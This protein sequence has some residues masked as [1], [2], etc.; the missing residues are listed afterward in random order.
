MSIPYSGG[1]LC[2]AVRYTCDAEPMM[3][4][5]CQCVQ[6]RKLSG[7]AHASMFAIPKPMLDISGVL[8]FYEF[9]A[10][11]GNNVK[12]GFCPECG[13]PVYN[14]N[15]GFPELGFLHASS[16]DDPELFKPEL[17]IYTSSAVAWDKVDDSL[18]AFPKMPPMGEK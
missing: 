7:S 6:C 15:D 4:E 2:G 10:D 18:L 5:H 1:C 16:L 8:K 9:V 3:P 12:R 14:G 11:S 17:L 13:S